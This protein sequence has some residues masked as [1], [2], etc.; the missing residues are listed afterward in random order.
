[1][2]TR[3]ATQI[4]WLAVAELLAMTLWF[5]A[6]A[7]LPALSQE[8]GLDATGKAWLT[9]AVQLG[10]VAGALASAW[11]NLPDV[12]S[13]RR[14]F[15]VCALL[16][17]AANLGVAWLVTSLAPALVLRF[18]TGLFLA[19]V[20]PPGMKIAA[21]HV[22]SSA[23][24][25]A[26]GVLVGALTLG[27]AAP[28]LVAGLPADLSYEWVL[29]VSS[30]CAVL[31]A[32]VVVLFVTDGPHAAP[33]APFDPSQI[34]RVLQNRGV[35]LTNLGYCG[36]MWELY[37]VWTWLFHFVSASLGAGA[38]AELAEAEHSARWIAF[39]AIG[40][41]GFIGAVAGGLL[42][43]RAGRT[44]VTAVA[45]AISGACCLLSPFAFDAAL[46]VLVVFGLIWGASVIAD[47]A[48]FSAAV[49]ELSQPAY[50][51]TALALQTAIGFALTLV[52]IWGLPILVDWL[53][54][55]EYAFVVL[56]PGPLLG[57]WA[58]LALRRLPEA[59]KLAGGRR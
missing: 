45:M 2:A 23:R 35:F 1:M 38:H 46:P 34:G 7:T 21:S 3:P 25:L 6:T 58:M 24:G 32:F 33:A 56:A 13:P 22:P 42:A 48:Q 40:V 8:W 20:Y 52:T 44:I 53:G 51:G 5:S 57:C 50:V 17:A 37:A 27:S 59:T 12:F 10:F 4:L 16:G 18:A 41:A 31:G 49:T 11:L 47:S 39:F 29:T 54:G 28:Q 36:H 30:V 14:L 26:I 9:A 15:F 19:G 43:D 55:W